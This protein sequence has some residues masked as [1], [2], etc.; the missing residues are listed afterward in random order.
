MKFA[1]DTEFINS[2]YSSTHFVLDTRTKFLVLTGDSATGKTYFFN[3]C[4]KSFRYLYKMK[5]VTLG[6]EDNLTSIISSTKDTIFVL[7]R[8]DMWLSEKIVTAMLSN[9]DNKYILIGRYP[10]HLPLGRVCY[11]ELIHLDPNII[12]TD[13]L[14]RTDIDK[15]PL[16]EF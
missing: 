8:T 11:K 12:C 6:D 2:M 5:V 7:D 16:I 15:I 1:K 10:H 4:V 13:N 9:L 14:S 3:A